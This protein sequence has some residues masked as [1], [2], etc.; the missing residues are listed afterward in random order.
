MQHILYALARYLAFW[1]FT[2]EDTK[3][4]CI[5]DNIPTSKVN[6]QVSD[7]NRHAS[8]CKGSRHDHYNPAV[9]YLSVP[10]GHKYNEY[11]WADP[12]KRDVEDEYF[13]Y[14]LRILADI[15]NITCV[16]PQSGCLLVW[17]TFS[18]DLLRLLI[19]DLYWN[20]A[21]QIIWRSKLC[22]VAFNLTNEK[23]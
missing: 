17:C 21:K 14:C 8:Q 12:H 9:Q 4:W 3:R 16:Q 2:Q 1:S 15:G 18:S 19:A 5:Q 20:L 10:K 23:L 6:R 22:S 7:G 13:H 11:W